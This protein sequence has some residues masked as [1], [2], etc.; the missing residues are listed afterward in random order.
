[1]IP[2]KE[3]E[4]QLKQAAKKRGL[5]IKKDKSLTKT[6]YRAMNP[7]AARELKQNCPKNAITYD[8]KRIKTKR[9]KVM[10]LRHEIIE[11]DEMCKGKKYKTAHKKANRFQRTIGYV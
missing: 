8:P 2:L 10:D 6:P 5:I 1:M 3:Q 11:F 4:E 7:H 9:M